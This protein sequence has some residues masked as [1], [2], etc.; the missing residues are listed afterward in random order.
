MRRW[1]ALPFVILVGGLP[2]C[3]AAVSR[4]DASAAVLQAEAARAEAVRDRARL[5]EL[6]ARLIEMER[7]WTSQ[8]RGCEAT[9]DPQSVDVATTGAPPQTQ[10]LRAEGDFLAE[11][12]VMAP[13]AAPPAA[14]V[15]VAA[16]TEPASPASERERLEQLLQGLR[17]YAFDPHS[18]L[19]PERRE[20]LRVLLRRDRQL[21]SM[22]P[23]ADHVRRNRQLDLM[24]PWGER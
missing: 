20:A 19:S 7:H 16:P 17:E 22:N 4:A 15:A 18:G 14:T 8:S 9:P 3:G 23:W 5:I 11:A 10:P 6:E 2:A 12:R 24:N 21:D 13:S 1:S